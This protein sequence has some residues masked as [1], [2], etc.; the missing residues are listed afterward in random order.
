MKNIIISQIFKEAGISKAQKSLKE[1]KD[2][3]KYRKGETLSDKG[4]AKYILVENGFSPEEAIIEFLENYIKLGYIETL[5]ISRIEEYIK[6]LNKTVKSNSVQ[7]TMNFENKENSHD[8]QT[9]E[10]TKKNREIKK[11]EA[12]INVTTL[13]EDVWEMLAEG[14]KNKIFKKIYNDKYLL[15]D[16]LEDI[17]SWIL[18]D[19]MGRMQPN[20]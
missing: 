15:A 3:I 10:I 19:T 13:K 4:M 2:G 17:F 20:E 9:I 14:Q 16:F 18:I 8:N 5:T 1:V 11:T 7:E 12:T 6:K